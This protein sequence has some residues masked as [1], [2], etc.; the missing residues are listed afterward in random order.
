MPG[1]KSGWPARW[2]ETLVATDR[3]WAARSSRLFKRSEASTL[4]AN[5][6]KA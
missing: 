2:R 4:F 6:E 3:G 5:Y 1:L